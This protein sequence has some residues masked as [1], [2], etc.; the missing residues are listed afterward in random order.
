MEKYLEKALLSVINQSFQNFEIIIVNDNSKD[1]TET[2]IQKFQEEFKKIKTIKHLKNLGVYKSRIDA[3]LNSNGEFI[4]YMDPDDMLLNPYLFEELYN[5]NLKYNLDMVEFSVFHIK[6]GSIKLFSP[7]SHSFNHYHNYKKKII[8]QPQLADI[9]FFEPNTNNYT[10]LFCRTIWN[11]LTRKTL[12]I[13]SI[14]YIEK[15]FH[16]H[17]LITADDTPIN[18]LNFHLANNYSNIKLPGYLYNIRKKSESRFNDDNK[19]NILVSYNYLLYF[20]F[21]YKY[22][23]DYKKNIKILFYELKKFYRVLFIFKNLKV[24]K[25]LV[26]ICI[27]IFEK[28][29]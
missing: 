11:K 22:Q 17:Y 7:K 25:Y 23:K 28:N 29:N 12:L 6:E 16:N 21:L 4:L 10:S 26:I 24:K 5:N 14:K 15:S 2:I 19:H 18:I 27:Y 9:L 1:N 13:K 8:Y 20:K 3:A